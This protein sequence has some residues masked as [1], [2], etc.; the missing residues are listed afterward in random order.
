MNVIFAKILE[1]SLYGSIAILAVLLFRLIFRNLP[2]RVLIVFWI[3]VAVRLVIPFNFTSPS[4]LM[5]VGKLF[6]GSDTEKVEVVSDAAG[7]AVS[8][9][10]IDNVTLPQDGGIVGQDGAIADNGGAVSSD[11]SSSS[12]GGAAAEAGRP[13]VTA[14]ASSGP[15]TG[16]AALTIRILADIWLLVMAGLVILFT[17]RYLMFYSKARWDSKSYDGKY[18][19]TR[20]ATPFV[21]GFISPKIFIPIH[22]DDD[23]KE[24]IL[25]HEWT[26]IKNKDGVIKLFSYFVLC[27][28]WFNPL[29]WL[30]FIMLCADIEMRVDEETTELFDLDM[31]KEYCMSL[32]KHAEA[33]RRGS[34]LQNTAF[35]G[36]GFGGMETKLRIKNLL[37]SRHISKVMT[38]L[39]IVVTFSVVFLVSSRSNGSMVEDYLDRAGQREETVEEV[40]PEASETTETT[41]TTTEATTTPSE[42]EEPTESTRAN[43]Y[44]CFEDAYLGVIESFG[45]E[46]NDHVKYSIVNIGWDDTPELI[47]SQFWD[48]RPDDFDLFVY[49]FRVDRVYKVIDQAVADFGS[50]MFYCYEPHGDYI[51]EYWIVTDS[52]GPDTQ[53]YNVCQRTMDEWLYNSGG[54]YVTYSYETP[55]I[56]LAGY[57]SAKTMIGYLQSGEL[58]HEGNY[59]ID[60][61]HLYPNSYDPSQSSSNETYETLPD[62]TA[63]ADTTTD[64]GNTDPAATTV[65]AFSK[66]DGVYTN[67]STMMELGLYTARDGYIWVCFSKIQDISMEW[68]EVRLIDN[69]AM[70][71]F[72]FDYDVD[73]NGSIDPG[74]TFYRKMT[75]ELGDEEVK[76]TFENLD[77]SEYNVNLNYGVRVN[78]AYLIE[79]E[80]FYTFSMDSKEPF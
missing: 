38:I 14:D 1:M 24:Y 18:F 79:D 65:N 25:N 33:D 52:E 70:S 10:D 5:N 35:S 58:P 19:E 56:V 44:T 23:E 80:E 26:Q 72:T 39:S 31:I 32:V 15:L 50:R 30:S 71:H 54:D 2:K 59:W 73:G 74:E 42:T 78:G 13:V 46:E 12:E 63:P 61:P 40:A 7:N 75:L 48:D 60:R 66:Y 77:E 36:L 67:S 27:I 16:K 43:R 11:L 45:G 62:V 37:K 8:N 47:V 51:C 69:V 6:S 21:I 55:D 20:I 9:T 3:A 28:H 17:V 49:T 29:V 34:F 4:S 41:E 22:F 53:P 57:D 68:S 64:P 76:L